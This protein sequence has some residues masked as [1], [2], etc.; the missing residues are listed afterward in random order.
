MK[1]AGRRATPVLL[2]VA[3]SLIAGLC[4]AGAPAASS[5]SELETMESR[6]A[7]VDVRVDLAE[8]PNEERAALARLIEAARHVDALFLRQRSPGNQTL[9]LNLVSDSSPLGRARLR[10]FLLNKGPWSELDEDRPFLPGIAEKSKGANFYPPDATREEIDAWMKALPE[11]QRGAA[12]GFFATIR[13]NP[14]GKL[15]AVPYSV[16][17]Q[18]ELAET[19]RLLREAASHTRQ[20]TLKS[21]LEKRAD[22]FLSND[23]Y[24]SDVAWMELDASIE[25]TIG[26]YEVYED[27]WFN[28][29]AA[30]EAFITL[31]D[32]EETRKLARF[33]NELQDLEDHLPI[34]PRFRR[35]KLGG[36]SPIRV[37]NVAFAAGDGNHG[38]QTAAFNLPNDEKVVAEKG[39]KRVLLRNFQQAKFEKVLVP[40]SGVALAPEDRPLV[41]FEPFFTHILMHELM[42][43]LGPQTIRVGGRD[44][45]VRQELKELNGPLEEAKADIS[46]LWALQYL[47]DKGVIDKEQ[48]RSMYVTFLASTFRTLR[49]GLNASHAK[50]MALQVNYLM[51][52][53]AVRVNRNGEFSLDLPKT[54]KAVAAL[55][56]DVMTL[57]AH[58]DYGGVQKLMQRMAVIRPDVQRV[59][60]RLTDVPVDIAPRFVTAEQLTPQ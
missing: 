24:A 53:G 33:S 2:S 25:P 6:F 55:A 34:E 35:A 20:P 30:F 8:L 47:M 46:G 38:V 23:Y 19:A 59:I 31:T 21:F 58:G 29:K 4:A 14:D 52:R 45:T 49:F 41:A 48:E 15:T 50:G 39:S 56:H 1:Y 17:Y 18:G 36:Y 54:K 32:A 12:T 44:T 51:D 5:V 22:A 11:A 28:F 9:L 27:E 26:P 40:I 10:Y 43:G 42:H 13:R 3:C 57:Q 16:E 37:V 60:D 7:P